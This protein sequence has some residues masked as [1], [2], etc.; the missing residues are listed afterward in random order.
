MADVEITV[1]GSHHAKAV[2]ERA[3][4]RVRVARDGGDVERVVG[5]VARLSERVRDSVTALHDA[6]AGPVV[7]W[8]SDRLQTWSSRPWNQDGD[9]LPL[10]HHAQ[11]GFDAE[12]AD[13]T[14]LGRWLSDTAT[15]DGLAVDGVEWTLTDDHRDELLSEVR[16]GAV[17]DARAKAEVYAKALGLG[18]V[19]VLA[20]A[21]AGMLGLHPVG[22]GDHDPVPV[23]R[24]RAMAAAVPDVE[25]APSPITITAEVDARFVAS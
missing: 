4:V 24:M 5:E 20:V 9:Q 16:A 12:F 19:S 17:A 6:E 21:D 1:R 2:P 11:V 25:L 14:S 10:V 13:F 22:G 3:K 8:S 15:I 7:A 18:R 23:A